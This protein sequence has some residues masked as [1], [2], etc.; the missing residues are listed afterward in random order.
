MRLAAILVHVDAGVATATRLTQAV[1]L[2]ERFG[3]S[4]VGLLSI[5]DRESKWVYRE[6]DGSREREVLES[7]LA[8]DCEQ[9]RCSFDAATEG[10]T[11]SVD[12]RV[13]EGCPEE[14]LQCEGRLADL[15]VV[16]Q[17]REPF[18]GDRLTY[19]QARH[20]VASTIVQVGRPV[21]VIPPG[22]PA[23]P[24]GARIMMAWNGTRE[25]ARAMH[26]ALPL[27]QR[28]EAVSIVQCTRSDGRRD[29]RASPGEY[30]LSWL[31]RHG[32]HASLTELL[33]EPSADVGQLLIDFA[34]RRDADLIVCGAYGKGR[35]RE[36]V[37]GGVT[38]TLL[39]HMP[40][41]TLFSH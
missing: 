33:M 6:A 9:A 11:F 27:L 26:D 16:A 5:S 14:A 28:A 18:A 23:A 32:I 17:P 1:A 15:I 38:D 3:A 13:G 34:H 20:L 19:R 36:E 7:N 31:A 30:A 22:T 35:V 2:A 8:D 41:A 4:L 21:L 12:W 39:R 10:A 24:V 29:L 25:S 37:L 40:V